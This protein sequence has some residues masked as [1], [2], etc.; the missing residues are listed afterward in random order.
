M[1]VVEHKIEVPPQNLAS[2]KYFHSMFRMLKLEQ[3]DTLEEVRTLLQSFKKHHKV[4]LT[5]S[6]EHRGRTYQFRDGHVERSY[7]TSKA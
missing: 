3:S 7:K 5:V 1:K 4:I 6:L 2:D